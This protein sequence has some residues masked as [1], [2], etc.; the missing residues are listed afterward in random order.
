MFCVVF[1]EFEVLFCIDVSEVGFGVFFV[2]FEENGLFCFVEIIG[3]QNVFEFVCGDEFVLFI[4]F[5]G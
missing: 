5:C 3:I 2:M 1:D 4:F